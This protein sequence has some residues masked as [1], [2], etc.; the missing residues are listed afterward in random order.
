MNS[1][2]DSNNGKRTLGSG[3][4]T[5]R[6]ATFKIIESGQYGKADQR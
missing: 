2:I 1:L 3:E 4:T 6:S 5:R